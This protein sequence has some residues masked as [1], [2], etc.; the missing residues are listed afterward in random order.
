MDVQ[1]STKMLK[2][3]MMRM[4]NLKMEIAKIK[5]DKNIEARVVASEIIKDVGENDTR[6]RRKETQEK[7]EEIQCLGKLNWMFQENV[8]NRRTKCGRS[9]HKTI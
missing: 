1:S 5:H 8:K 3:M 6:G 2:V 4:T 7:N 9:W